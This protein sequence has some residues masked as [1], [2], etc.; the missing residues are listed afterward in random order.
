[1][2]ATIIEAVIEM[3]RQLPDEVSLD[4]IMEELYVRRKVDEGLRQL[5]AGQELDHQEIIDRV[6][7][8]AG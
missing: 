8:W 3:I 2:H 4:D 1:M 7:K 6:S 5:D